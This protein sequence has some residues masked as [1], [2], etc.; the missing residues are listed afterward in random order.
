MTKKEIEEELMDL[1]SDYIRIQG[2]LEK[3]T[4]FGVNTSK[5]EQQLIE[6][7]ARMK[8]LNRKLDEVK[9]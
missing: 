5:G 1:K 2:D 9:K 6:M 7:E 8:E 3:A 4:S